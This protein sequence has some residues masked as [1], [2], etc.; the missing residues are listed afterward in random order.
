M[1]FIQLLFVIGWLSATQLNAQT[2][3]QAGEWKTWVIPSGK[4]YRLPPP[5]DA[6]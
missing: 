4:A 1:K 3:P 2:E 5:P 6:G